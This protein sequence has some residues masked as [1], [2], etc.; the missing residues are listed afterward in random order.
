VAAQNTTLIENYAS[1]NPASSSVLSTGNWYKIKVRHA[2]IYRLTYED[3]VSI[4]ITDPSQV[5]IFGNGSA[6]VPMMNNLPRYDD[7]IENAI[8]M[9]SGNDGVFNQG[10]YILFYGQGNVAWKYNPAS[11]MFE[12][13][14]HLYSEASY[15]FVTSGDGGLRIA[16]RDVLAGTPSGDVTTFNDYNFREKE[17][18]NFI[19]SGRQWFGDKIDNTPF[20]SAFTF[21]NLV[22]SVPV[23]VKVNALSRSDL[24]K[25][26]TLYQNN[27]LID[28]IIAGKVILD[29]NEG[30]YARQRSKVFSFTASGDQISL[31]LS[32][33]KTRSTDLAYIDYIIVNARRRLIRDK[34]ALFFR[35]QSIAGTNVLMRYMVENCDQQ[36][37]IWEIT[38]PFRIR[39]IPASL[40]GNTLVFTDSTD[41]LREY[42]VLKPGASFPKPEIVSN[43]DD[44]GLVPNQNLHGLGPHQMLIITHP[45][46]RNAADSIAE[47]HRTNDNLNVAVVDANQ[48]YNE[49]S[50]GTRDVSS[51][52]DFVRMIYERASGEDQLKF[53]LLMGDGSYNNLSKVEGNANFI[54]TYQSL[55]SLYGIRSYV[56]DDFFGMLEEIEGGSESMDKYSMDIGIGRLPVK[57]AEEAL[58]MY[59]KIKNYNTAANKG[60]WQNNILFAGDDENGNIHMRQA[61]EIATWMD[62][63]QP[64]FSV[65]KVFLDAYTQASTSIGTRYPDVNRILQENIRK[66]LLIFN[67]TGHGGE[68]GLADEAIFMSDEISALDNRNL[69]LFITATCEFS[70]F[71]DLARTDDGTI[72]ESTSAGE[73]SILNPKGGCIGL[74]TTTRVVF[75]TENHDLNMRFYQTAFNR[76]VNGNIRGLGEALRLAKNSQSGRNK[77]N[78]IL[79]GDPALKLAIPNY[80]VVTDSINHVVAYGPID[81]LKA[82]SHIVISGHIE[83]SDNQ[84]MTSFNGTIF[85]SVYDKVKTVTTLANDDLVIPMQFSIREDIL[86]KG[87]ASVVNGHFSFEFIVPKDITYSFGTGRITYFSNNS[88]ADANG[89]FSNFIIGGTDRSAVPD[90]IGPAISLWLND[91]NFN[92]QGITNTS[93]VIYARITDESGINTVGNGIGH[94]ITGVVDGDVARPV[95]MNEFFTADLNDYSSGVLSYPMQNLSEGLHTLKVRV[96]DIYNNSSEETIEFRVI[97][98]NRLIISRAGNYPNPATDHTTF[99]FEHNQAGSEL[100][101]SITVYDLEGR[102]VSIHQETVAASGFNTS[103]PAWD[104]KDMNGNML[105]QGIYPYRIRL[106]DGEGRYADSFHK[107]VV[108]R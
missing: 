57:T 31:K 9:N 29:D 17:W 100:S 18:Y 34:D 103:L 97:S 50:S 2:G 66:G 102:T 15:Y 90:N 65:K 75:S 107:L 55:N 35:D 83:D 20:D 99:I 94:D 80:K 63:N 32:Y 77:L 108:I 88:G 70:R 4:G 72:I 78:F 62:N 46:F 60:D 98:E 26:F 68:K 38:D 21:A 7:L 56:T 67:Y 47:F 33:N 85:P 74:I 52:R 81:T 48:I 13:Q 30:H 16:S 61:N 89:Q 25:T 79:L 96:W 3:L 76:D 24:T 73:L 84:V 44:I 91:E 41:I 19:K 59:R 86:Y 28:T 49:F 11:S 6:M 92:N 106:T 82:F 8:F 64:Q 95:I 71:D 93:P 53:L 12:H 37:E 27:T 51:I 69:P 58:A 54:P 42:V 22:T 43:N 14:L 101:V 104:L 39:K 1:L 23:K 10:D 87:K 105:K 45:L 36:S 5:K 40:A